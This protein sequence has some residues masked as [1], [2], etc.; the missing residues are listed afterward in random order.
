MRSPQARGPKLDSVLLYNKVLNKNIDLKNYI[1]FKLRSYFTQNN[2][3]RVTI[4]QITK[5][6]R[7]CSGDRS[8]VKSIY[9]SCRRPSFVFQHPHSSSQM[10]I[11][12]VSRNAML[13][14]TSVG[15]AYIHTYIQA[16]RCMCTCTTHDKYF[17]NNKNI[18][19]I[20]KAPHIQSSAPSNRT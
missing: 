14:L 13:L 8:V 16:H 15:S 2:L 1:K 4:L 9:Y 11:T 20:S 17:K 3:N 10:S 6:G 18:S 19:K 7:R 5:E 12:P